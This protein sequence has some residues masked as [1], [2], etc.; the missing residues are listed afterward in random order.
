MDSLAGEFAQGLEDEGALVEP[1]VGEFE[2]LLR[3]AAVAE[4]Q[5]VEIQGT[6]SPAFRVP[7]PN[8]SRL[9]LDFEEPRQHGPGREPGLDGEHRVQIG[10]LAGRADRVGFVDPG[11]RDDDRIRGLFQGHPG[12]LEMADAVAQV[13]TQGNECT[14]DC[15][16]PNLQSPA[17]ARV[18]PALARLAD[19]PMDLETPLT[20]RLLAINVG[21]PRVQSY[22][23]KRIVTGIEKQPVTG[24]R[25][26]GD[27]G[28]EGD[29]QADLSVHG[30]VDKAVYAYSFANI[31]H[32]RSEFENTNF[33][34]ATLG[35]NLSLEDMSEQAVLLGDRFRVGS[36]LLEVS[37][38]REP[39]QKLSLKL[40]LPKFPKR[41]MASGR[42]GFYLRVL[43]PGELA[44][45]E[46]FTRVETN[47]EAPSIHDLNH[48]YH[49]ERGESD[50]LRRALACPALAA[51]W[52]GPLEKRLGGA[53]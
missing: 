20:T 34:R 7:G 44:A 40:G 32:W 5:E 2:A 14:I 19:D 16:H 15:D 17:S 25:A 46:A 23:G 41:F 29:G 4:E 43:E 6:G 30:G 36:A 31:L 22:G 45:G 49:F 10:V 48:C 42:V 50:T 24:R 28:L 21:L 35:E 53:A 39:C 13:R 51:A 27:Q 33:D 8:P 26:V 47:P 3:Q 37:Q 1:G 38:P 9:A 18:R 11:G 52:R 12:V